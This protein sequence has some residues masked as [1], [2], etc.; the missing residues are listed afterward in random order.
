MGQRV[1]W[2]VVAISAG[3]LV[4]LG[5]FLNLP[6]VQAIRS[7]LLQWAVLLSAVA[8]FL[9]LFNLLW[10]VHWKRISELEKGWPYSSLLIVFFLVTFGLG[11]IFGP[12]YRVVSLLFNFIQL[13]VE[14]ALI[15]ILAVALIVSG[16]RMSMRRRD[17]PAIA[18]LIT[19]VLVLFGS[20]SWVVTSDSVVAVLFADLKV[21]ITQV[22]AMAGSRGILLGIALGSITSGL[23]VL[24]AYDR[25]YGD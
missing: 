1:L 3:T 25:P 22:W 24:L 20:T 2:T 5:Y 21:W 13:P 12:D 9:G 14:T 23:R 4:L 8:F 15:A 17:L 6:G 19:A 18:F 16:V 7:I 11:M 10:S